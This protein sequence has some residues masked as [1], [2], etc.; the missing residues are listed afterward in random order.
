MATNRETRRM[1][2]ERMLAQH[3]R[4]YE[5]RRDALR[6][7]LTDE[8]VGDR[9]ESNWGFA[10]AARGLGAG[11]LAFSAQTVQAIEDAL[12]QLRVGR[13]GRCEDCDTAIP[14]ARLRALPFARTCVPCQRRRDEGAGI[15]PAWGSA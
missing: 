12:N 2:L 13:Y 10:S 4:Q 14:I 1:R 6:G 15:F 5:E 8:V 3:L 9:A 7:P 11:L